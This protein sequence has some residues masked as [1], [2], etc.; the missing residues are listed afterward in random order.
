MSA[1]HI[2]RL[3][4]AH[5]RSETVEIEAH[6]PG[7]ETLTPVQGMVKVMHCGNY[8]EV[9]GTAETITTLT[10]DRCLRHYNHKLVVQVSEMIWLEEPD[11]LDD[12][13]TDREVAYD[14]LVEVLP[15]QGMFHPELWLY[16][17]LCLEIPARK[18]CDAD[19]DGITVVDEATS[20]W[21]VK[22][23]VDDRW[24]SLADLK[25]QLRE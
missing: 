16:E 8:L 1:I 5:E 3:L 13:V 4:R 15:P 11:F 9:Q 17:Q 18:L 22:E 7:L 12:G 21:P 19:C 2:P 6:L 20:Q 23:T 14:E 25:R 24:A 10:C